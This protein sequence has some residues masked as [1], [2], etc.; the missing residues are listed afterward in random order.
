MT[1]WVVLPSSVV[2]WSTTNRRKFTAS[3]WNRGSSTWYAISS[4]TTFFFAFSSERLLEHWELEER[5]TYKERD[6][7]NRNWKCAS[8]WKRR[9]NK[10]KSFLLFHESTSTNIKCVSDCCERRGTSLLEE[11]PWKWLGQSFKWINTE[12]RTWRAIAVQPK[13]EVHCGIMASETGN[14]HL[15]IEN[16]IEVISWYDTL[17]RSIDNCSILYSIRN[18]KKPNLSKPILPPPLFHSLLLVSSWVIKNKYSR[19]MS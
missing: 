14:I 15:C 12:C 19:R 13:K 5:E 1:S 10:H 17:S 8:K 4:L 16:S 9:Q 7:Q 3:I 6:E 18:V 2:T 11:G